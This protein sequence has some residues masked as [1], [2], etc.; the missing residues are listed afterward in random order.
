MSFFW[1]LWILACVTAL[2]PLYFFFIGLKDGSITSR[3]IRM[4]IA[5]LLVVAVVLVG[6]IVL[7]ANGLLALA[8]GVLFV[9]FVPGMLGLAY[10][11]MI[12]IG[13]PR[14]N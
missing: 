2:V 1:I 7:H 4:W 6:S 3:N 8:K 12:V 11:L 9:L 14:W 10:L 13:K 5:L